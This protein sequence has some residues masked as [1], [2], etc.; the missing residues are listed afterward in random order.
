MMNHLRIGKAGAFLTGL[1]V[2][3]FAVSLAAGFFADT[4]FAC[5]FSSMFIALGFVPFMAALNA[6]ND[7]REKHACAMTAMCF[8]AVYVVLVFLVYYAQ[9]TTLRLHDGWSEETL[10]IIHYGHTGSLFFNYDLLGYAF[11]SLSTFLTGMNLPAAERTCRTLRT[12][13][14]LHG[15]FFVSCLLVPLFPIFQPGTGSA[16]GS[17]LLLVW[18]AY[19]FPICILGYRYLSRSTH[20]PAQT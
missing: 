14:I 18:C 20:Q 16:V 9:C 19:F 2:F 10:S 3:V 8:A 4:L 11:M 17:I 1:S 13:L 5:C 7:T 15:V 12:L 6:A